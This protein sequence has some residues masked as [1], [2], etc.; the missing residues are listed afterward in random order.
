MVDEENLSG[1]KAGLPPLLFLVSMNKSDPAISNFLA[2][3]IAAGDFPSAVYLIAEKDREVFADALGNAVVE[4]QRI[5]ATLDTVYDL[6][7]LTKPLITGLLS[8]RRV[9]TGE[10]ALDALVSRYLPEFDRQ[11][12]ST[13]TVRQLLT[14]SAGLPAWQPLY[15]LAGEPERVISAIAKLDLEYQP[16]TRVVYSDLGFI[17]LGLLL[18]RLSGKALVELAQTEI[19]RPL[20]LQHTFFNPGIA[21]QTGDGQRLRT[22]NLR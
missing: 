15:I 1:R 9:E 19:F 16:G 3:R 20:N 21:M 12:K 2:E 22:R 7:S 5:A 11:D 14:H 8:A 6:A 13:I 18:E 17:V 10:L 4:P